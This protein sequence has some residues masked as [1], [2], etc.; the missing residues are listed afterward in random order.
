VTNWMTREKLAVGATILAVLGL[1]QAAYGQGSRKDDV[2]YN[3][4]GQPLA[5]ATVRVCTS[6]AT[7]QPCSPLA[8]IY[9][10]VGLTQAMANP[11]TTDGLGN[12]SFYAAPG[13]YMIELDGPTITTKQIPNVILPND[14]SAPTFTSVTT[15]SGISALSLSLSGNLTVTGSAAVTGTL[16]AG[17]APVPSTGQANSWTAAQSFT[18]SPEYTVLCT[19]NLT[20]D[21]AAFWNAVA[22]AHNAGPIAIRAAYPAYQCQIDGSRGELNRSNFYSGLI[23][24]YAN[25]TWTNRGLY[26]TDTSGVSSWSIRG[27]AGNASIS[28]QQPGTSPSWTTNGNFP[29]LE[30][31]AGTSGAYVNDWIVDGITFIGG[32]GTT[33]GSQSTVWLHGQNL[34]YWRLSNVSIQQQAGTYALAIQGS[35]ANQTY[36]GTLENITVSN[37]AGGGGT[38]GGLLWV[39]NFTNLT[40]KGSTNTF[41]CNG[42]PYT[43]G[44]G[45]GQFPVHIEYAINID[46]R[47][48]YS[49]FE[50][51]GGA[52]TGPPTNQNPYNAGT[53]YSQFNR[54][55]YMGVSYDSLVNSNTGN[56]PNTSAPY[57]N[58]Y[59]VPS[60]GALFEMGGTTGSSL[61]LGSVT[62]T[63]SFIGPLYVVQNNGSGNGIVDT[64]VANYYQGDAAYRLFSPYGTQLAYQITGT[65][66]GVTGNEYGTI[67]GQ[68]MPST[69]VYSPAVQKIDDSRRAGVMTLPNSPNLVSNSTFTGNYSVSGLISAVGVGDEYGGTQAFTLHGSGQIDIS[70]NTGLASGEIIEAL[71]AVRP[72]VG[73]SGDII[74]IA[75]SPACNAITDQSLDAG[76]NLN[77]GVNPTADANGW[78]WYRAISEA[79]AG[80]TV[81]DVYLNVTTGYDFD[82]AHAVVRL[83]PSGKESD[84][85]AMKELEALVPYSPL[86][87]A[88]QQCTING[89]VVGGAFSTQ[90]SAYTLKLSDSWVNVTGTTTITVPHAIVGQQWNVFN[91]GS[92]TVTIAAD[93]GNVNGAASITLA[94]NTG[95]S[96]TC[97][98]TNC[99][100]H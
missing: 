61:L 17:G 32:S 100:A 29:A 63:D 45:T 24:D 37:G 18:G 15:T 84:G 57:T 43:G 65:N 41:Q 85:S 76:F 87:A 20:A 38:G 19:N 50:G 54:V 11:T 53:T 55:T 80:S 74:N 9:S 77:V 69:F 35:A 82:Y 33:L 78:Y 56:T 83:V 75:C 4:L 25:I 72:H 91:S 89:P 27:V 40:F 88:N 30:V 64:S 98:G 6:S 96:V 26:I 73:F 12:Y 8:N 94:A 71:V 34:L 79:S 58:A 67:G 47:Q 14:P 42:A 1:T 90:T 51:C 31:N 48:T 62:P 68:Q 49:L 36:D 5:G 95:K 60:Y 28:F 52:Y 10:D 81:A 2:V 13:R 23:L 39:S 3:A 44:P 97:D 99:F 92:G 59:W 70:H 22:A 7:G 46:L 16:T 86:C 66:G 21:T 93:S